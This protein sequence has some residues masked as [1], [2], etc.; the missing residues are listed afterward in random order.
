[1]FRFGEG[2]NGSGGNARGNSGFRGGSG[3][4]GHGRG[5]GRRRGRGRGGIVAGNANVEEQSEGKQADGTFTFVSKKKR[6]HEN[7]SEAKYK[8]MIAM[9]SDQLEGQKLVNEKRDAETE[10]EKKPEE[11]KEQPCGV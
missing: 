10:E 11:S 6:V 4:R 2:Q 5:G 9:R 7:L 8:A 1:M 3:G